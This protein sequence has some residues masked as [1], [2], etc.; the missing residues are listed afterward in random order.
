MKSVTKRP[1]VARSI[2]VE[3]PVLPMPMAPINRA[4][5]MPM[6][7]PP[8]RRGYAPVRATKQ[9]SSKRKGK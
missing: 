2:I 4:S 7:T 1:R 5:P 8:A 3:R 6:S 9:T